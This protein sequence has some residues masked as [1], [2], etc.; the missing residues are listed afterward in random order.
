VRAI[1]SAFAGQKF[2]AHCLNRT[3]KL[4][5]FYAIL[6]LSYVFRWC[7]K[8]GYDNFLTLYVLEKEII[9]LRN[10]LYVGFERLLVVIL[11][12]NISFFYDL[13]TAS[14]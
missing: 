4:T 2:K 6:F 3:G 14:S 5:K 12:V 10:A 7:L 1:C 9:Y 8:I 13:L 11:S